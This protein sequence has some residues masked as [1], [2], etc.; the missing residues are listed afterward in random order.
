[1]ARKPKISVEECCKEFYDKHIFH[2]IVAGIDGWDV[3]LRSDLEFVTEADTS[4]SAIDPVLFR[5]E[6]TAVRMEVFALAFARKVKRED[7][8]LVQSFFTRRYLEENGKLDIWDIMLEYNRAISDSAT[9][10]A[11]L[12]RMEDWRVE[13][14]NLAKW[15]FFK[16]WWD[17]NIGGPI[18]DP[19]ASTE[20]QKMLAKCVARVANRIGADM[21]RADCAAAKRLAARLAER[22]E[23]DINLSY[24]ALFRLAAT[25]FGFYRGAEEYLKSISL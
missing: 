21:R 7:L 13:K 5:Q 25:I 16:K 15:E 4:F 6:M 23:C 24:E 17:T 20:E 18:D 9:L 2:A 3:M 12:E 1:M 8:T 14:S 22:L 10:T 11:T 19:S